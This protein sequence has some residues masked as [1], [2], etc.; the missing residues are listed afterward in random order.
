VGQINLA[1]DPQ[2][3]FLKVFSGLVQNAYDRAVIYQ[4]KVINRTLASGKSAQFPTTGLAGVRYHTPG[5]EITGA[6]I[7]M[8]EKLILLDDLLIS[9]LFIA[10]IDDLMNHYDVRSNYAHQMGQA[11]A[12]FDDQNMSRIITNAARA[13]ATITGGQAGRQIT[14]ADLATDGQKVWSAIFNAGVGLDQS[15]IPQDGRFAVVDPVRYALALRSEKPINTDLNPGG[16]GSLASGKL[17]LINDIPLSKTNNM[18]QAND[19][20]NAMM[21]AGRQHDYSPTV[22][23]VL[24]RSAAG[25]VTMQGMTMQMMED[26]RRQ[27][28]LMIGKLLKGYG[29][30]RPEAAY[31]LRTAAPAG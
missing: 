1:G 22:G 25:T 29:D 6:T 27:G 4:D 15:D 9:D 24:H 10:Y 13:A 3:L 19:I 18:A 14:D 5:Q 7:P 8:A 31:E 16:N 20:A 21:P 17:F 30:L 2:A 26:I 23:Q 12:R 28:H 11:L